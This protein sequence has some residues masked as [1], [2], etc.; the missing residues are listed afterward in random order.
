M[1]ASESPLPPGGRAATGNDETTGN[2]S[3]KPISNGLSERDLAI[4]DLERTWWRHAGSK[5][6]EIRERFGI[7]P[8][9]YYQLLNRLID[10]PDAIRHDPMLV[11]RLRRLRATRLRTRSDRT[12]GQEPRR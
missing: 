2:D 5:E 6:R 11:R 10:N 12:D 7:S 8:T 1:D 3:G 4:L 9:R